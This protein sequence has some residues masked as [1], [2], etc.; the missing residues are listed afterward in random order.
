MIY[1][2]PT[3]VVCTICLFSIFLA[4]EIIVYHP[5]LIFGFFFWKHAWLEE[6]WIN[7]TQK[8]NKSPESYDVF[9]TQNKSGCCWLTPLSTMEYGVHISLS[10]ITWQTSVCY[11]TVTYSTYSVTGAAY[12]I[13]SPPRPAPPQ[14]AIDKLPWFP[15]TVTTFIVFYSCI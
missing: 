2:L 15:L 11:F 4:I 1:S 13:H 5:S 10:L 7:W 6:P 3:L 12:Y 14:Q 9:L 8:T